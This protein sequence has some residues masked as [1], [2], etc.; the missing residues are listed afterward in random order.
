MTASDH[1]IFRKFTLSAVTETGLPSLPVSRL[2]K[3]DLPVITSLSNLLVSLPL[4]PVFF[5]IRLLFCISP[6][7]SNRKTRIESPVICYRFWIGFLFTFDQKFR[8]WNHF[9][10][11]VEKCTRRFIELVWRTCMPFIYISRV[12]QRFSQSKLYFRLQS[13]CFE[14]FWLEGL[15]KTWEIF[16][17]EQ[18]FDFSYLK[19]L[20][21]YVNSWSY[22][23]IVCL[24]I[25]IIYILFFAYLF[26]YV[27]FALLK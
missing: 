15:Q 4:S 19:F 8:R 11:G 12:E 7:F 24:K 13:L 26:P 16:R 5:A 9:Q 20:Q 6:N 25:E 23:L 22:L 10:N 17:Y 14:N 18:H 27:R 3:A 21:E 1:S 2:I